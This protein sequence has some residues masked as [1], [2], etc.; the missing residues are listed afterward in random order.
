MILLNPKQHN[1]EYADERSRQIMLKTIEFFENKGKRQLKK[2][3]RERVWYEDLLEFIKENEIFATLLT[4]PDYGGEDCR[5]DTWRNC[6]F[7]EILAFYGLHYWYTWQVSILGLGPI[8]MSDNEQAKA[9]A[10]EL[11]KKGEVFAFGLSERDHG[12]DIYSTEMSLTPQDDGT[13]L[14]NGEKYYIGNG[15]V[16]E[17]V[18]TFGKMSDTGDYVFFVANYKNK[19]YELVKNVVNAQS[20]VADFKLNDYVVSEEDILSRGQDA[21]DDALNTVNVGKYNLGW[22]SVGI[23]T[24]A[25]YEALNHA[26]NRRLYGMYVTDFPHVKQ[27]FVDA[28]TR[29]V[30]MKLF[31]LRTADY[32]RAASPQDRRYLLYNPTVKMKVTTQGEEVINLLWDVIAAKG[33]ERDTYFEMAARDIRAMP[34]LEGTVHVN[35]ALIVKFMRNYFF[36]PQEY[37]DLARQDQPK[38]DEFLFNQG[39]AS[40]LSKIRFHDY[41][42]AYESRDVANVRLF[43]EQIAIFKEMLMA[44]TP[45]DKQSRDTDFL[46]ALGEIFTLVVYGQLILE[47]ANIY[48]LED[49]LVDQIFDFMVRDFAKFALQLYGKPATNQKQMD[50]LLQMICKPKTDEGRYQQVWQKHVYALKDVYEMNP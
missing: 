27:M 38:H 8:W 45:D 50:Y 11:L 20:Y 4:P 5:W 10:G 21:W 48:E 1:R 2:D 43:R 31:A 3:D 41:K 22:A 25:F 28:Y 36:N 13:Y 24:H 37:P 14:A 6:E 40:G 30:A 35:I 39:P 16:A 44:A 26:A 18:S 46:L 9:R 23:C 15:N 34:K 33:F 12:A 42:A 49:G 32:M 17:M 47:N 19:N 29:L 7:N